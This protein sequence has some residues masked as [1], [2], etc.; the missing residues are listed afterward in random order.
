M[1]GLINMHGTVKAN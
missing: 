1:T